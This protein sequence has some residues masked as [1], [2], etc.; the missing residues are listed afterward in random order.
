MSHTVKRNKLLKIGSY[1]YSFK[2]IPAALTLVAITI[3]IYLCIW[4]LGRAAQK[5]QF[6]SQLEQK[7]QGIPERL[8]AISNPQLPKHRFKP[9]IIHGTYINQF[10]FLLDNQVYKKKAGYRVITAF[11]SPYLDTWVLIDRGWIA[12]TNQ[13]NTL[14]TIADIYGVQII[15][16]I[17]NTIPTGILLKVD[18][19]NVEATWPIVIQSLDYDLISKHL[20]HQV[21][22]FVVQLQS[23]TQAG[24]CAITPLDFGMPSDKHIGY[25]IQWFIFA[26]LVMIY[27]ILHSFKKDN[28]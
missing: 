11:Q 13:P 5:R 28:K 25:A 22:K 12:R 17:I 3:L 16:G 15:Q 10:T 7:S 20:H 19:Y 4:Q 26:V 24:A 21:L 1:Y 8:S 9:V 6:I 18:T 2:F 23:D 27:Y 14:P